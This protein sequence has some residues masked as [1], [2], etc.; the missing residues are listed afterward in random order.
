MFCNGCTLTDLRL[1]ESGLL[2]LEQK[3]A[4]PR[5]GRR[6][7]ES[8]SVSTYSV[9]SKMRLKTLLC[10]AYYYYLDGL[11]RVLIISL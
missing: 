5:W 11:I 8:T 7:G 4:Q 9:Q 2:C 6:V 10:V 3:D 1:R